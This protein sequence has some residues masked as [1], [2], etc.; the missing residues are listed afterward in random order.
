[1]SLTESIP[2]RDAMERHPGRP[3]P[4]TA[5]WIF[6][7]VNRLE[8][9]AAEHFISATFRRTYGATLRGFFPLI[10]ALRLDGRLVAACGLRYASTGPLF[11]ESYLDRPIEA[12]LSSSMGAPVDRSATVEVGNLAVAR[13]GYARQLIISLT[14]HLKREQ[15]DWAVFSAV[16]ALRNS[17]LRLGVPI[18][19]LVAADRRRLPPA[20]RD[21]WGTYYD[22]RPFVTAVR[23]ADA[24]AALD[25]AACTR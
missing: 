3:R 21:E 11:L 7:P 1:M 18:L 8:R 17:F 24:H 9:R 15:A 14:L 22:A 13:G 10:M 23:V 2:A 12:L 6:A 19:Q 20:Q 4:S 16:P 5:N 25:G